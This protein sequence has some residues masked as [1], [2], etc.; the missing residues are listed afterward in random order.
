MGDDTNIKAGDG[1]NTP[2]IKAGDSIHNKVS[3]E[4]RDQLR[5][6]AGS[7][8]TLFCE[9]ITPKFAIGP[10]YDKFQKFTD[11]IIK[12]ELERGEFGPYTLAQRY[13]EKRRNFFGKAY[14]NEL[15]ISESLE[16]AERGATVAAYYIHTGGKDIPNIVGDT[17]RDKLH[18]PEFSLDSAKATVATL[19]NSKN[20]IPSAVRH[21]TESVMN[22]IKFMLGDLA[23]GAVVSSVLKYGSTM[24]QNSATRRI[25]TTTSRS[26]KI[27]TC[28]MFVESCA[29]LGRGSG[30]DSDFNKNLWDRVTPWKEEN[31]DKIRAHFKWLL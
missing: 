27:L 7:I 3:I 13:I 24:V 6:T 2:I 16:S 30:S 28:A 25:L 5:S 8:L 17:L 12:K 9:F 20:T 31:A 23:S 10:E 21:K 15:N 14:N 29:A 4:S 18:M 1:N 19:G 11:D 26:N 22:D